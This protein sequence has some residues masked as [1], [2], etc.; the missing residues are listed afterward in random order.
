MTKNDAVYCFLGTSS[1]V[2][3]GGDVFDKLLYQGAAIIG[4]VTKNYISKIY[5]NF[6]SRINKVCS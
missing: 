4:V 2:L 1:S 6:V 5:V 3:S